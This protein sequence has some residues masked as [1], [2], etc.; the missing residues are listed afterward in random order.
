ML[1]S[2]LSLLAKCI[3]NGWGEWA[4]EWRKCYKNCFFMMLPFN[5][6]IYIH[7]LSATLLY[8]ILFGFNAV[9][10]RANE[11][12]DWDTAKKK[13]KKWHLIWLHFKA[14]GT[15]RAFLLPHFN[16]NAEESPARSSSSTSSLKRHDVC[17]RLQCLSRQYLC[18]KN[19]A[20]ALENVPWKSSL[21]SEI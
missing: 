17:K 14:H 16:V 8:D 19:C 15:I 12:R 20:C 7:Y 13:E 5:P 18:E 4:R 11:R 21:V 10:M 6:V 1:H 9:R 3:A 2:T